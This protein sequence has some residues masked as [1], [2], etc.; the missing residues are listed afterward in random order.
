MK[1]L[2][3]LLLLLAPA[4]AAETSKTLLLALTDELARS[5][6]R[7]R[8]EGL[9]TPYFLSYTAEDNERLELEA[10]F[11]A[12]RHSRRFR[13]RSAKADLRVGGRDFDNRHYAPNVWEYRPPVQALP[14]EDDYDALRFELW[15]LTDRAYK[16]ALERLSQKKAYRKNKMVRE[17]V[18]DLSEAPVGEAIEPPGEAPFRQA[19]WER[20]AREVSDVFRRYPAVQNGTVRVYWTRS[21]RYFVDSE[22]RRAVRPRHD[23]EVQLAASGQAADGTPL[24]DRRDYIRQR[25]EELPGREELLR[26]AREL[27]EDI[28]AL[29]KAPLV[30][31]AY[32]GPVLL[33]GQ[34]AGELFNQLL[35]RNL[36]FP[37]E[38]WSAQE[39][40]GEELYSGAFANRLG[41]RVASPLLS[42]EDDPALKVF[43]GVPLIG[44]YEID[45]EGVPARRVLLVENGILKD[46]LMSRAPTR[47]RARSNGHGRAD[48]HEFVSGRIGNLIVRPRG[49]LGPRELK[50]ELLRQARDF[51]LERAVI[52]RRLRGEENRE[53]GELLSAPVLAYYVDVRDG[54]ERLV[55]NAKFSGVTLR[56]LRDIVAAGD[57]MHVHNFYQLG[58]YKAYRGQVQ[59]SI[60]HPS[61]LV[62]EMELKRS[63]AKP[64][65]PPRLLRPRL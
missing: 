46:L 64:D 60:V 32:V 50:E 24:A 65:R 8:M 31:E 38:V 48:L 42:V 2:P 59:A 15:A 43:S 18:P 3:L 10:D 51:G 63:D 56:A 41:L 47:R 13:V 49:A 58:P 55:R 57:A 7:L 62:S 1:A 40:S 17:S 39:P 33:E 23:Y 21:A 28:T 16:E 6:S 35:A 19:E 54:S 20:L 44:H 11:G 14:I 61:V 9:Q 29:A 22:G 36:S 12:L 45:D 52:I 25:L 34:A 30:E 5:M 27:A 37:R 53:E 26:A 4:S